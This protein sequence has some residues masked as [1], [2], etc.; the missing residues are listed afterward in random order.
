MF[1]LTVT[2]VVAAECLYFLCRSVWIPK[3]K[4]TTFMSIFAKQLF[5]SPPPTLLPE[6][7]APDNVGVQGFGVV[8]STTGFLSLYYLLVPSSVHMHVCRFLL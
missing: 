7:L 8:A 2:L 5:P 3:H 4:R 6:M 1:L